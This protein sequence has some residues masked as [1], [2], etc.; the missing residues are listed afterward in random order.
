[1]TFI[2][3]STFYRNIFYIWIVKMRSCR[4]HWWWPNLKWLSLCC[5]AWG[6]VIR[7]QI[8]VEVKIGILRIS[9][10]VVW[11]G[12]LVIILNLDFWKVLRIP[13]IYI[14]LVFLRVLE[15][16]VVWCLV[17]IIILS[18]KTEVIW[19]MVHVKFNIINN[20]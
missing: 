3:L 2:L 20:T 18:S 4:L 1:M 7:T 9:I 12:R 17:L 14:H 19:S 15:I 10:Q 6:I 16:L 5:V 13:F 8:L 11:V